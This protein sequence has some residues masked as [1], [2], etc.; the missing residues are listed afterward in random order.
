MNLYVVVEGNSTEPKVYRSWIPIV[1]PSL[2]EKFYI[3]DVI[4]NNF[5]IRSGG[6]FP[7]LLKIISDAI[8]DIKINNK[9]ERLVVA[10][11]SEDETF[12]QKYNQ[13]EQHILS[14]DPSCDYRI[15]IQ[16]FC[17]EAWALGNS[18][19]GPRKPK[20]T[21]LK[22]Y[23]KIHD[24]I[25][26]DPELLPKHPTLELNRAQFAERYLRLTIRDKGA[27]LTYSKSKPDVIAHPSYFNQ[28][29]ERINETGH[30]PSF[31]TFI[32]AFTV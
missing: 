29:Q 19:F 23:K 14:C 7:Y 1:N 3:N 8:D 18:K 16:H 2:S 22:S 10:V 30:I 5:M 13:I 17:F 26:N 11:D 20:D 6:G 28:L 25:T 12:E 4:S 27:H 32:D 31:Q 24:V 15:I 21:T 9:F